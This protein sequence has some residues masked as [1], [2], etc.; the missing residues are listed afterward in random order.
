MKKV[1]EI[2]GRNPYVR[3]QLAGEIR[4]KESSEN[5]KQKFSRKMKHKRKEQ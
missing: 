4:F 2:K 5:T 1:N 3:A